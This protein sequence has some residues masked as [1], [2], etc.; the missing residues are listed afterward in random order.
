MAKAYGT[1]IYPPLWIGNSKIEMAEGKTASDVRRRAMELLLSKVA[2]ATTYKDYRM[3]VTPGGFVVVVCDSNEQA[4]DLLNEVMLGLVFKGAS[5]HIVHLPEIAQA[6]V[7][8]EKATI[9]GTSGRLISP[10]TRQALYIDSSMARSLAAHYPRV[11]TQQFESALAEA[12]KLS[13][14]IPANWISTFLAGRTHYENLEFTASFIMVWLIVEQHLHELWSEV[15]NSLTNKRKHKFLRQPSYW[16][17]DHSIEFLNLTKCLSCEEYD[18]LMRFK[19]KR[20]DIVHEMASVS[21]EDAESLLKYVDE[22]FR[23]RLA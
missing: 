23:S 17:V 6:E 22:I 11:N 2:L 20:N 18:K 16:S 21:R 1:F 14:V 9:T 12:E 13:E 15:I 4:R 7:D 19:K 8:I 5:A 3:F 10:R